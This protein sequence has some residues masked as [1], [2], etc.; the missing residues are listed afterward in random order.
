NHINWDVQEFEPSPD[1]SMLAIVTNEEGLTVLHLFDA[2]TGREKVLDHFPNGIFGIHWHKNG[3]ELGFSLDSAKS[4]ADAYSLEAKTSKLDRW[5]F[6]ETGGLDTAGFVEPQLIR[7]NSFDGRMISGFLYR[8]PSR[9]TGKRPVI[10]D[11]HGG[12]EDQFQ[13]YFL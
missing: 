9:F 8:P 3:S 2:L 1:G 10:I 4:P 12:P 7:W 11:I 5:T 6:S 13:P